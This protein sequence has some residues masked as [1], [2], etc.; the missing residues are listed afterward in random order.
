VLEIAEE[1][2]TACIHSRSDLGEL[3]SEI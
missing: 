1:W 3:G 2:A